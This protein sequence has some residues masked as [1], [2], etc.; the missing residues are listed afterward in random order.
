M[1]MRR[2]FKKY[3]RSIAKELSVVKNRIRNLIGSQHWQSDGEHKE[4]ILRRVLRSHLAQT[5]EVGRGFIC[6]EHHTSTQIDILI[7]QRNKPTLF[8]EGETLLVTPDAAVCLIEVKTR[9]DANLEDVLKKLAD[10]AEMVRRSNPACV[11]GLFV[12][13]PLDRNEVHSFLLEHIQKVS[14]GK[15]N[16][17]VNWISVGPDI[18]IRYWEDGSD[19]GSLVNG[20]VWHSYEL[21]ELSHAYF[22]SNVVWETAPGIDRRMQYAWFPVEGGKERFRRCYIP[23]SGGEAGWF[24]ED[25][26]R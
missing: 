5:L 10:N 18:F 19:I 1:P 23:L 24:G 26:N 14:E 20:P 4:A 13:E 15:K 3:H 25:G 16:R 12:F 17:V 9:I 7:T 8:R 21:K 22:V 6:A 2:D 11:V